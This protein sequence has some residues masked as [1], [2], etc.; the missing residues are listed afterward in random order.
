[1]NYLQIK[2]K[3]L[4][5]YKQFN[6]EDYYEIEYIL[7]EIKELEKFELL[8]SDFNNKDLE[9]AMKVATIHLKEKKPLQK[10]FNRAYFYGYS[11]YVDENVLTPRFDSEVLIE[12]LKNDKFTNVLDLCCGS[13]ALGLTLK[14]EHKNINLTLA[15]ISEKALEVSKKNAKLL[16]VD[17]NFIKTDMFNNINE[18]FD[19]VICNPPYIETENINFLDDEVKKFDPLISL[20]GGINGL[21][22]YKII[23]DNID[24]FLMKN[25][26]CM[27]EIGYNQG[28]LVDLFKEKYKNVILIKDYN[29][30]DRAI[31]IIKE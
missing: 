5:V 7:S 27:L 9:R 2:N 4:D 28:F 22:F 3:L 29:N 26:I 10:I 30:L 18:R 21:K 25:G 31:K 8:N 6:N 14:K 23:F 11:F 17:A 15:D 19:L 24:N 12:N 13:G 1:M 16:N 20:D